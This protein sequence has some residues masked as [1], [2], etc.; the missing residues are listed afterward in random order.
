[1]RITQSETYRNFSS[2]LET[3]NETYNKISRQVS[4]GK[5]LTQLQDS[6]G[7]SAELL[8][9][10]D[11]SSDIDVYESSANT[12]SYYLG[13]ADSAL[14]NVNN[15]LTS[16]YSEGSQAASNSMSTDDRAALATNIRSLRDQILSLANSQ[17]KG[18]YIFAGSSVTTAPYQISGDSVTY[19]GDNMINTV[20][21]D[22]GTEVQPGVPGPA[23]FDSVFSSIESLLSAVDSNDV[24]AIGNAL[25]RFSSA[26]SQLG[27][28]RGTIGSNMTLLQNV[29][30]RLQVESTSITT[31]QS[32]LQDADMAQ[33]TVQLSQVQT[34]L[35]AAMAAGSSILK[36]NNL[37][38]ILG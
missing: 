7:D 3:L 24:S 2:D 35:Q 10:S 25:G 37:F 1:M 21:V 22:Q 14:N 26:Y 13:T 5:K 27:Q 33:A 34:A 8:S 17:A 20:S 31:Q 4:S 19:C 23:A 12:A 30:A 6:P 36:Q 11:Q 15:L 32:N 29:Q 28:A 38:D 9:L 16:I 18:R